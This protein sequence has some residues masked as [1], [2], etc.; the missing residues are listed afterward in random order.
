MMSNRLFEIS[1][2]A[3]LGTLLA[4]ACSPATSIVDTPTPTTEPV[5]WQRTIDDMAALTDGLEIPEHFLQEDPVKTGKEFDPNAYF[6]VLDRLSMEP[7]YTSDYVYWYDF[8]GGK[9][10]LYAREVSA[11]PYQTFSEYKRARDETA[12]AFLDRVHVDGSAEGFFQLVVLH[13]MGERFYLWW[14]ALMNDDTILTSQESLERHL[15]VVESDCVEPT[16]TVLEQS[17]ALALEPRIDFEKD[18]VKVVIAVFTRWGGLQQKTYTI[19][20]SLP[21]T[22]LEEAAET[23]IPYECGVVY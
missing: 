8:M 10:V 5:D 16:G 20:R 12:D 1:L 6:E 22:L 21:H 14:H 7:G 9:P 17:S 3:L 11:A 18:R 13:T 23:L 2:A 4:A 15:R 19:S